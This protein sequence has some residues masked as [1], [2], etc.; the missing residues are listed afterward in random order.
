[1]RTGSLTLERFEG[2]TCILAFDL[3]RKL[4]LNAMVRLLPERLTVK[5]I[6]IVPHPSFCSYTIYSADVTDSRTAERYQKWVEG[7]FITVTD[8]AEIDYR[9]IAESAKEANR[10]NAV[11]GVTYRSPRSHKPF[12]TTLLMKT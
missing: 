6:I 3:A 7:G 1:M 2:H 11:G 12:L 8:G 10:L 5:R 4:D 9:E